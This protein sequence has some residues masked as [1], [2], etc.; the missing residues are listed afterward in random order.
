MNRKQQIVLLIGLAVI[1]LM[2]LFPPWRGFVKT[3]VPVYEQNAGYAFLFNP[4]E[5]GRLANGYEPEFPYREPNI[6]FSFLATQ[7][8]IVA[9]L[10]AFV[11]VWLHDRK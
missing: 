8:C 4:P 1:L 2:G 9:A 3:T 6:N 10:T 11:A 7:W 5:K